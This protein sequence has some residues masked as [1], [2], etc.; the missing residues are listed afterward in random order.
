MAKKMAGKYRYIRN[1]GKNAD[2]G[3]KLSRVILRAGDDVP[4]DLDDDER[5]ALE[6][7]GLI[8]SED[9]LSKEGLRLPYGH[10]PE[11]EDESESEDGDGDDGEGTAKKQATTVKKQTG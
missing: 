9:R 1:E 6:E 11:D 4:S 7:A 8:V 3:D 5:K 2:G 10:P